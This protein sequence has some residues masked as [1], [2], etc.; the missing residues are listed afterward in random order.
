MYPRT[1]KQIAL[2]DEVAAAIGVTAGTF[3][4]SSLIQAIL[5]A[6]VDLL[7]FGGIGTYIKAS[8]Q[9]H[10]EAG[11]PANDANRVDAVAVRARVIGEGANLSTTQAGRIEFGLAGGRSNTDFIDNSAGVDCSDNEVNIKIALNAEVTA[12]TLTFED[13]NALLV[14]MTDAV[15]GIV[16]EDNRLQTLALS[17]AERGGAAALPGQLGVI[18]ALETEGRLDRRVEGLAGNE[19]LARRLADGHGLTRPELAVIL[20]HAKL[21]L[22]AAIEASPIPNDLALTPILVRSFPETMRAGHAGAIEG[23][24]LRREIIATRVANTVVNRLGLIAPF[25]LGEEEGVSLARVAGAYL[26]CD[27]IFDLT[28]LF[29]AIEAEPMP[30]TGRLAL[31]DSAAGIVRLHI[32]DLLRVAA[33]TALPGEIAAAFAPGV[34]RLGDRIDELVLAEVRGETARLGVMLAE[35]GAGRALIDRLVRLYVLDGAIATASLAARAGWSEVDVVAAYVKLGAALGLD[36][37]K[38]A[39]L[40]AVPADAWERLLVAGLARDFEQLRIEFLARAGS[41]GPVAAVD[42]WLAQH[43]VRVD[44][45]QRLL[46]RARGA[47]TVTPAMLAQVA[48]QARILLARRAG[49]GERG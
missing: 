10:A 39:A 24:R 11:D 23:H 32:A 45:F 16:L 49:E 42:A 38:A 48:A 36:W 20:S 6:P 33:A 5:K 9:S 2:A 27:A 30:E 4:P 19:L 31:L 12:G 15:A 14:A 28:G 22:Q 8:T 21:A 25:E 40:R 7:W 41:A 47:A 44:R 26:A 3:D 34:H 1:Q 46:E 37:A 17:A 29:A 43:R 35:T 13:R 18:E